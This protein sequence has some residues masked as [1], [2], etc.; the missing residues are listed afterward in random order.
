MSPVCPPIYPQLEREES[1][2]YL[3]KGYYHNT[4][5]KESRK[6]LN[7]SPRI[8]FLRQYYYIT[9]PSTHTHTH[10]HI[11]IYIYIYVKVFCNLFEALHYLSYFIVLN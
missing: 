3:S 7:S 10:S 11:Y 1:D 8:N 4:K 9:V 5:C 6:D 2:L